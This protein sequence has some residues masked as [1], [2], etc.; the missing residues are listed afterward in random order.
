MGSGAVLARVV[1][2]SM[3]IVVAVIALVTCVHAGLW[4]LLH[5]QYSSPDF[6]GQLASVSYNPTTRWQNPERNRPADRP[7]PEQIRADLRLL[8]SYTRSIR[9]YSSTRGN[10]LI[11]A[12]AAEFGLKVTIGIWLS[13]ISEEPEPGKRRNPEDIKK[14]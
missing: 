3:R 1:M 14:N 8:S 7:T 2:T 10:E 9:T 6:N 5:R 4:S 12:I 11:P 13:G